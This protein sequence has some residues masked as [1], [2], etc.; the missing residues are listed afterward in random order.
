[1]FS[2]VSLMTESLFRMQTS[3]KDLAQDDFRRSSER[4]NSENLPTIFKLVDVLK[5]VAATH[6]AT[7]GQV[8][9]AWILAQ[10]EDCI[11]IPGTTKVKVREEIIISCSH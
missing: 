7:A 1:M 3:V 8:S 5:S 11:P 2:L 9:L 10:G 6:D 4:F